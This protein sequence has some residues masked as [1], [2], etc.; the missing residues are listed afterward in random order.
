MIRMTKTPL[1]RYPH[2]RDSE[3]QWVGRIPRH[4]DVVRLKFVSMLQGGI[5]L[6]KQYGDRQLVC[7]P[8]LRV[9]NVQDGY[10]DLREITEI[11]LPIEDVR[12][13]ELRPGDVLMTEGGDNDKL[14]RGYVWEAQIPGCLHQNHI[15]CVRPRRDTLNPRFL[16]ALMTS[17]HGKTYFTSTAHQ[18]TNLASTNSTKL[19]NFP[20]LLPPSSEQRSILSFLVRVSA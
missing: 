20:L 8:Y 2:Y 1:P 18:T 12:R 5:T 17:D 11:E 15:F 3:I 7:R 14:G 4:W 19:G 6:G 9:A 13:Y 10:L 16:A